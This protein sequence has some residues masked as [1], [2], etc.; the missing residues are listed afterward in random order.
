M[1]GTQPGFGEFV[2]KQDAAYVDNHG[3]SNE[4][5]A[6]CYHYAGQNYCT[7]VLGLI[8]P[9]GWCIFFYQPP[10]GTEKEAA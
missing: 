2:S 5:C 1:S 6:K 3:T 9:N 7:K 4:K 8:N 10:F